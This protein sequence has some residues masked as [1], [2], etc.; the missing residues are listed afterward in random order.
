MQKL[1]QVLSSINLLLC[2]FLT[3]QIQNHQSAAQGISICHKEQGL[4]IARVDLNQTQLNNY[5]DITHRRSGEA[6]FFEKVPANKNFLLIS[7]AFYVC[8]EDPE[9]ILGTPIGLNYADGELISYKDKAGNY[10]ANPYIVKNFSEGI[11]ADQLVFYFSNQQ[12]Q[13]MTKPFDHTQQWVK[14]FH[15]KDVISGL[16][17]FDNNRVIDPLAVTFKAGVSPFNPRPRLLVTL[18]EGEPSTIYITAIDFSFQQ[19]GATIMESLDYAKNAPSYCNNHSHKPRQVMNIDGGGSM[20]FFYQSADGREFIQPAIPAEDPNDLF[21]KPNERFRT[22]PG[23]M[24]FTES[25]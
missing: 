6:H 12:L 2:A 22:I 4:Y 3:L 9:F 21:R 1:K 5:F 14:N 16:T 19:G 15:I 8:P 25:S 17:L 7:N 20:S 13:V 23:V 24:T 10:P 11:E 18:A